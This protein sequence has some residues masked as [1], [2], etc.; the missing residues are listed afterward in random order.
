MMRN[1]ACVTFFQIAVRRSTDNPNLSW[2]SPFRNTAV[3]TA[4]RTTT[5][6]TP[7]I[8]SST[9]AM[10]TCER[11]K[12]Q[13]EKPAPITSQHSHPHHRHVSIQQQQQST[14]HVCAQ[15]KRKMSISGRITAP[16]RFYARRVP[17]LCDALRWLSNITSAAVS[18][19]GQ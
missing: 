12:A 9:L 18:K 13:S 4:I 15:L 19:V 10:E 5:T 6:V 8:P 11:V 1:D 14:N 17:K 2:N 7:K 3:G 16:S